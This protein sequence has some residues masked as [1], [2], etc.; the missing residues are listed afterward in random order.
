[1][2]IFQILFGILLTITIAIIGLP[3]SAQAASS[4][5]IRVYDDAKLKSQSFAGQDFSQFEF[6]SAKLAKSN[7]S[8]ANLRGAVF[9]GANLTNSN[10]HGV[11]F[12]D[13]IAYVSDLSG[14]DLSDAILTSAMMIGSS[15]KGANITG[16]DFSFAVLD[17]LQVT[18]LC[19]SA[20]GTNPVTGVNTRDSLE[21]P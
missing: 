8:G 13:G 6:G 1:M 17:R 9:N 10:L 19:K 21:C 7:F 14:V 4:S 11:D 3:S 18:E 15:L 12:S 16:A 2:R 5:A 20:S